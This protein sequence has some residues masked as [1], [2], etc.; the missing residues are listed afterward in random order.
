[1]SRRSA[2]PPILIIEESLSSGDL[3]AHLESVGCE[4][5]GPVLSPSDAIEVLGREAIDA[6]IFYIGVGN[7]VAEAIIAALVLR[8]IPFAYVSGSNRIEAIPHFHNCTTINSPFTKEAVKMMVLDLVIS[9][10]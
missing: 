2:K 8:H 3:A 5:A 1:M 7:S 10:T 4:A 9:A 6:A